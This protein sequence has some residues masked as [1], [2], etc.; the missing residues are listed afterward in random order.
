VLNAG[1]TDAVDLF[2]DLTNRGVLTAPV[3]V[4]DSHG[5]TSGAPGLSATWVHTGEAGEAL[6][7]ALRDRQTVA[8]RGPFLELST[9]PGA[10]VSGALTL[11]VRARAPSWIVVDELRLLRDGEVVEEVQ[12]DLASFT[13]SPEVDASY[14]VVARGDQPMSPLSSATPWALS[15]PIFVDVEGDGWTAPLPPIASG[16]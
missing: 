5:Y 15:A 11:E 3:G 4:S 16:Q 7:G 14:V 13:L 8:S 6:A 10:V 2:L 9:P 1:N 12:G